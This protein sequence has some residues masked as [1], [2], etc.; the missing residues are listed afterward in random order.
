M[1]GPLEQRCRAA[2]EQCAWL[3]LGSVGMSTA[4]SARVNH[5]VSPEDAL[6]VASIGSETDRRLRDE[7]RD[8]F[9]EFDD[10][11]S[12]PA[13]KHRVSRLDDASTMAW[14]SFV[15]PLSGRARGVI[16]GAAA[17]DADMSF[18]RSGKSRRVVT[19]DK[20]YG[21]LRCRAAF[22]TQARA[23]V[24]FL[25]ATTP[26]NV[27]GWMADALARSA[28][29]TKSA[30]R[31]A[32]DRLTEAGIVRRTRVG[33][34]DWFALA[35]P[36]RLI[37]FIG[38]VVS[39][40]VDTID[41]TRVLRCLI[42]ASRLLDEDEGDAAFVPARA[43]LEPVDQALAS[44]RAQLPL[45]THDFELGRRE[46]EAMIEALVDRIADPSRQMWPW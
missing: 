5:S 30:V 38:P 11:I 1:S 14:A 12:R 21:L 23:D 22:G 43:A 42:E 4:S 33:N 9:L 32:L 40:P 10:L 6:L 45:P 8:W 36:E 3:L 35:E 41:V 25:L 26:D 13:L 39:P 31:D 15:A 2:A 19:A 34:A 37:A 46:L 20:A 18:T 7:A 17:A 44:L 16:P 29:F 24:L 27:R 28:G